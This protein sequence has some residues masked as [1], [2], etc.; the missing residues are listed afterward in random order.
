MRIKAI[1]LNPELNQLLF[2]KNIKFK[3]E[4]HLSYIVFKDCS[5]LFILN[6]NES[7]M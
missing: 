5:V 1:T 7:N 2:D 6:G 3:K 4:F